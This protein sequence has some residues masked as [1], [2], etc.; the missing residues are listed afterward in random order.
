ML[1]AMRPKWSISTG[2]WFV[3]VFGVNGMN[4]AGSNCRCSKVYVHVSYCLESTN[5][6]YHSKPCYHL[7]VLLGVR[8]CRVSLMHVSIGV[9]NDQ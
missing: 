7:L 8:M 3:V 5:P 2:T 1:L 4:K 6:K 9:V